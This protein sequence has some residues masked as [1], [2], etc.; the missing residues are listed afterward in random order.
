MGIIGPQN[1]LRARSFPPVLTRYTINSSNEDISTKPGGL[2]RLRPKLVT[3]LL[4][5]ILLNAQHVVIPSTVRLLLQIDV[6]VEQVTICFSDK[7][8]IT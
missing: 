5:S 6:I 1:V 8:S 2:M 7:I 3:C 4:L